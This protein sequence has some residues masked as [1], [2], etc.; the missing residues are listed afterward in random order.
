MEQMKKIIKWWTEARFGMSLHFGLYSL[1]GRGVCVPLKR[2]PSRTTDNILTVS[3][4][5][6]IGQSNGRV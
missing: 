6:R 3:I 1:A 4:Q 5:P 2:C